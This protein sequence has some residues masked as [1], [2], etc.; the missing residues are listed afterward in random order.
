M[1]VERL[2]KINK[3]K[4]VPIPEKI[5]VPKD[6]PSS[7][8]RI[9]STY[10]E[11]DVFYEDDNE[12]KVSENEATHLRFTGRDNRSDLVVGPAENGGMFKLNVYMD[13]DNKATQK[14]KATHVRQVILNDN[15]RAIK[16]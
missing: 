13:D 5:K 2:E 6:I 14:E 8:L 16:W 15:Y 3:I 12:N 11:G 10:A 4:M 9:P 7:K 1:A